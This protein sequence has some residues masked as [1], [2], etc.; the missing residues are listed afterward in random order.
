MKSV[1]GIACWV[2]R[3]EDGTCWLTLSVAHTV[4]LYSSPAAWTER[5]A[6][7]C[8]RVLQ[9]RKNNTGRD[10]G[11]ENPPVLS[12]GPG[13]FTQPARQRAHFIYY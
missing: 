9:Y 10:Q 12:F 4:S 6:L 8:V 5:D 7:H 3:R 13:H 11:T 1:M 2:F